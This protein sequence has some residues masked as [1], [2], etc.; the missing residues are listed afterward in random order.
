MSFLIFLRRVVRPKMRASMGVRRTELSGRVCAHDRGRGEGLT[1][2]NENRDMSQY[3]V[4][5]T[6][7]IPKQ[8]SVIFISVY[9]R[10]HD[11]N[12]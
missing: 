10:P 9:V 7:T 6:T 2:P 3:M 8:I 5:V 12:K 4:Y 11:K 1:P